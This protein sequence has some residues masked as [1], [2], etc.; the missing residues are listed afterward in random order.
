MQGGSCEVIYKLYEVIRERKATMPEGSYTAKLF[1]KGKPYIAQKVGE[2]AVETAVAYLAETRERV[3]SETA[4]LLYHLL[5]LLV[6]SG[7]TLDEVMEE[8][9]RRMK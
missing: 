4:D 2:E 9:R 6:D 8:L 5:V 7:I 1:S 3:I